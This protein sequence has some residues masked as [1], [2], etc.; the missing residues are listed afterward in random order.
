MERTEEKTA[1][2]TGATRGLGLEVSRQ[3]SQQGFRV[4]LTGRTP[5]DAHGFEAEFHPLDVTDTR[6]INALASVLKHTGRKLDALIN[7]AGV[8]LT[9][10]DEEVARKTLEVNFFGAMRVTDLLL[11]FMREGGNV[12]MVSSQMGALSALSPGLQ[13]RFTDPHLT[14]AELGELMRSFIH[15][16]AH[17]HHEKAGWPSS[18]YRVSK[19]GLNALVRLLAHE[20]ESAHIRV[21]AVC[22]GWVRTQMGGASAPRSIAEGAASIVWAANLSTGVTGGFFRD[23]QSVDW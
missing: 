4:M 3:L 19:I 13:A 23:G 12:V 20:L 15:D 14:R 2:V 17:K 18:A 7:N 1:L 16:V 5:T 10:F 11:P 6:S 22:P 8:S 9:G 21:N